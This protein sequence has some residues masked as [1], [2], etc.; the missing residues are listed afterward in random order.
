MAENGETLT[1]LEIYIILPDSLI[2][3]INHPKSSL[4]T[5]LIQI[6]NLSVFNKDM[7]D[8]L[9]KFLPLS[10]LTTG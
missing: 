2:Y 8:A 1:I 10:T 4:E 5:M 3:T 7:I 9:D 6:V